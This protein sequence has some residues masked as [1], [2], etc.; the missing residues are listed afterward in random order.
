MEQTAIWKS[1]AGEELLRDDRTIRTYAP[2][3]DGYHMTWEVKLTAVGETRRLSSE[4]LHGHYSGLSARFA[5]SMTGGRVRLPD[6]IDPGETTSPRAASGPAARWCDYS[7]RL[8]GKRGTG[9]P[10][11][12]GIAM[13]DHPDN[14]PHPVTWFI[15]TE[16][17]GFLSANPTWG[18]V[19]T[20]AADESQTW[21]WG[22]WV[23]AGTPTE[24][25]IEEA[26]REF[27]RRPADASRRG[28]DGRPG[29]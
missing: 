11:T 13:F 29:G 12:A 24:R 26:Y 3:G 18:T 9:D 7:G 15:M 20:L 5:R 27:T 16:P 8:D 23:H 25:R 2:T 1:D 10:W 6:G 21:R 28:T 4:T 14:D 22:V 19:R 17:F